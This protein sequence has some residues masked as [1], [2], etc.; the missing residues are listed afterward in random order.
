MALNFSHRSFFPGGMA[1]DNLVSPMR[2]GNGYRVDGIPEM[3]GGGSGGDG[4]GNGWCD[5]DNCFDYG[6]DR[7]DRGGVSATQDSVSN[8]IIDRLPTDPFGMGIGTTFTAI[9]GWLEDL[10][11]EYGGYGGYGGD[12]IGTSGENYPLFA[13]LN[14]IWNNAVRF[15]TFPQWGNVGMEEN[16]FQ[17][18]SGFSE[19]SQ[20][21][22]GEASCSFS[23]ES[24]R[25]MD[26]VMG[27]GFDYKDVAVAGVS[28]DMNMNDVNCHAG[29]EHSPHPAII[30][31]L[32][33]LGLSGL[34]AVER[35]CKYLHFT[36]RTDT[37]LWKS[38]H[39]DQPL[40]ER[41]T[42][43][44]LLELTSRAQ[45]KLECLSLVECS[46]ITDDGLRRV[47]EVNPKIIKLSV[48]GCTRL[49][50]EGIVGM[51]KAYKN[52]LG[53]QGVKHL[54]IGGLYGVTPKHFEEIKL[55]LSTDSQQQ[56][57]SHTDS[58]LQGHSR[59]DSQL[60]K[61]SNKP[62]FY[63]RWNLYLPCDDN[64]SIDIELCPRCENLRL[65]Y[66]CPAE[67][68]QGVVGHASQVCRACTLCIPRC[69]Q[70]GRC[71][72]DG[73]YEETF[74]LELL[75]SNCSHHL[76]K[77]LGKTDGKVGLIRPSSP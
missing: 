54:H 75:C 15:H 20:R 19:Y 25:D 67:G 9:T 13:G 12:E 11:F 16:R 1:E 7:C 60:K 2:M 28:G 4:F 22:V 66:D 76:S 74:C 59:A 64:R 53:A 3:S 65:V 26:G 77:L 57:Q 10:D 72:N 55:L 21:E 37:L 51:L 38:I 43:D 56:E 6:N 71:I 73:E 58:Q 45:G 62:H 27:F 63:C 61:L 35:V 33:Y 68:C 42:D 23:A 41:I 29:D 46:R 34:L 14:F 36:V 8:D 50:I 52:S 40:N 48:P 39:V 47:L 32:P 31:S 18:V 69:S 5:V 24:S 44:V 30:Y 17:G 70:C 49:S